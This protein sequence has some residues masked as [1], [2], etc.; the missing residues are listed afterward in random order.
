M[1]SGEH[2]S[3][4]KPKRRADR[5]S[6]VIALGVAPIHAMLST[7]HGRRSVWNLNNIG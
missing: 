5:L 3:E 7:R 2:L 1:G 4:T 6:R